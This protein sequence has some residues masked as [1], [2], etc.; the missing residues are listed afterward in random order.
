MSAWTCTSREYGSCGQ[1]HGSLTAAA[2]CCQRSELTS[3]AQGQ[4]IIRVPYERVD[5]EWVPVDMMR[6]REVLRQLSQDARGFQQHIHPERAHAPACVLGVTVVRENLR[7]EL[8]L[9]REAQQLPALPR[10]ST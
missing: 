1:L 8:A 6:W 3:L 5:Q 4:H 2:R 10:G 7:R 9:A